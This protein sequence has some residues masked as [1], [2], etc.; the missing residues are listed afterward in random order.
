M[1]LITRERHQKVLLC[2]DLIS[3]CNERKKKPQKRKKQR[4]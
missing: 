1:K 2:S 4:I 3:R